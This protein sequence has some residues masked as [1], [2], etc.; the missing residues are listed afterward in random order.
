MTSI[1]PHDV[2][3]RT[4]ILSIDR[5]YDRVDLGLFALLSIEPPHS[6]VP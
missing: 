6:F 4:D 2:T 5:A 1:S 3:A